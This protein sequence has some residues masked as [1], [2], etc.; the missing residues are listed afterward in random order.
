LDSR[1]DRGRTTLGA[2]PTTAY[3]FKLERNTFIM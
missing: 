2:H 1:G 3:I